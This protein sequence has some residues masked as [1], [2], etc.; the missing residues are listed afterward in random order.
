M[1]GIIGFTGKEQA[2]KILLQG[3][4]RLE[5]RGYDSA[6][7]AVYQNNSIQVL[8]AKGRLNNLR[9]LVQKTPLDSTCG[10]GHTRWATHGE[11]SDINAHPHLNEKGNIAIVH[12]GIIENYLSLKEK[13]IKKGFHFRSQTDTEVIVHLLTLNYKDDI[14]S[15]IHKTLGQLKGSFALGIICTDYPGKIFCVRKDNPLVVGAKDENCYLASDIPA[16]LE[17]TKSIY[18]MDDYELAVLEKGTIEFYDGLGNKIDKQPMQID[19][20]VKVAQKGGYKH[21][22]MKEMHE[23]P[24]ALKE[25]ISPNTDVADGKNILVNMPLEEDYIKKINHISIVACGTAYHAGLVGKYILERYCRIRT[26][27]DVAS[28]FRYKDPIIE[29][30]DLVIIISQSGETAD[31]VAAMREAQKKGARILAICNV[32]GSTISREADY[33]CHTWAGPEIAVASTKAYVSQL[34]MI[35]LLFLD[36]AKKRGI[37]NA[38]EVS[39]YID[40]LLAVPKQVEDLTKRLEPEIAKF[41]HENFSHHSVFFLGRGLD[42]ALAMEASLKLKEIS[43][44]H[45]EAYAAGELK[46]GTIA[47]IEKGT[48]VVAIS[49]QEEL[50]EKMISNITEVK[51]RGAKILTVTTRDSDALAKESDSIWLVPETVSIFRPIVTILP[52]QMFAYYMA[53]EKGCDID[54]PRNLAKSVTVE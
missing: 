7:I 40:A 6:G 52:M 37:M 41:A 23:Q 14:I 48:L 28:E 51:V 12:N 39:S 3:L 38:D 20:D 17:Y 25:T 44:I 16:I 36:I 2:P 21:F 53:L 8:K 30:D 9:E 24:T 5:Y 49:S 34:M 1:C 33:V 27:A 10:I 31:T 32:V 45:S 15:A 50:M 4:E 13:L 35:Y 42:Y 29:K 43:Y 18:L 22:M 54:K 19:W 11:P 46:H 47:L 26:E